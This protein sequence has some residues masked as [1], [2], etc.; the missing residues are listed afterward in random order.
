VDTPPIL[1]NTKLKMIIEKGVELRIYRERIENN[2]CK[3]VKS[4]FQDRLKINQIS[5]IKLIKNKGINKRGE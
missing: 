5:M 3:G 2:H 4:C 1:K